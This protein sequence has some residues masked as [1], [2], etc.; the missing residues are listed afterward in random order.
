MSQFESGALGFDPKASVIKAKWS[1][2]R[3]SSS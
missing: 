3:T 1:N 2:H